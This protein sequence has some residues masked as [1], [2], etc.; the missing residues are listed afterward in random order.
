MGIDQL[1]LHSI[2]PGYLKILQGPTQTRAA[3]NRE[4]KRGPSTITA[5]W[6]SGATTQPDTTPMIAL[7]LSGATTQPADHNASSTRVIN[8]IFRLKIAVREQKKHWSTVT[9]ISK[10]CNYFALPQLI[11]SSPQ[12]VNNR[13]ILRRR[14]QRHQSCSKRRRKSTSNRRNKVWV[15]S[16]NRGFSGKQIR[17]YRA[18]KMT[19]C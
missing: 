10:L 2:Q 11:D 17:K 7:D 4:K 1:K 19:K 3:Q 12:T 6:S 18:R 14:S 8:Q 13:R 16:V 5:Q 9:K 15:N